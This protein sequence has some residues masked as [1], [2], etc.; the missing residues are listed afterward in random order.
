MTDKHD[1]PVKVNSPTR[2]AV[3]GPG[4]P[5]PIVIL[6][7]GEDVADLIGYYSVREAGLGKIMEQRRPDPFG[8]FAL[9]LG[10][11]SGSVRFQA[12]DLL[13]AG[14]DSSREEM[15]SLI[16]D[17]GQAPRSVSYILKEYEEALT[18]LLARIITAYHSGNHAEIVYLGQIISTFMS[19]AADRN[20]DL[21]VRRERFARAMFGAVGIYAAIAAFA[22]LYFWAR[23]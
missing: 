15:Y 8:P 17:H 18:S 19:M 21:L 7:S 14:K 10:S 3:V 1:L 2:F 9:L 16:F 4:L 11:E 22:F 23:R 6:A 20:K 5:A 12:I 13:A